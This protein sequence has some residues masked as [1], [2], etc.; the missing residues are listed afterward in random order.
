MIFTDVNS[1]RA[2]GGILCRM[3][4]IEFQRRRGLSEFS[5][6]TSAEYFDFESS[7][8]L[9]VFWAESLYLQE[10]VCLK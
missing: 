5:E 3:L 2:G 1:G 6:I 8:E 9:V 4:F 10:R 7:M